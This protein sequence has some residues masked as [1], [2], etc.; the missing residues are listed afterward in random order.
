MPASSSHH[1]AMSLP[2]VGTISIF[3]LQQQLERLHG[4]DAVYQRRIENA[5]SSW[6]QCHAWPVYH[7]LPYLMAVH[8]GAAAGAGAVFPLQRTMIQGV[9]VTGV[10]G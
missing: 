9:V 3:F 4:P 2:V 8:R 5:R 1:A 7:Q 10:K 6:H